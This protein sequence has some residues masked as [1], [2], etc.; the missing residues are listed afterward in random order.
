MDE[1]NTCQ[2]KPHPFFRSD[3]MPAMLSANWHV[4]SD[5]RARHSDYLPGVHLSLSLTG[6]AP[7]DLHVGQLRKTNVDRISLDP[8][9]FAAWALTRLR[10]LEQCLL[11]F[12]LI[13]FRSLTDPLPFA[14]RACGTD[15]IRFKTGAG[16][17]ISAEFASLSASAAFAGW[18]GDFVQLTKA[19]L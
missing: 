9:S 6:N 1:I 2:T 14:L 19:L 5:C 17:R 15:A 8:M 16:Q 3:Q 13:F 18:S 11:F 7:N 10:D 12:A 4:T